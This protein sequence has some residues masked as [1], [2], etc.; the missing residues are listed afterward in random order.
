VGNLV[1]GNDEQTQ[2]VLDHD[3]LPRLLRLLDG[4]YTPYIRKEACWTVSNIAAGNK[5]QIQAVLDANFVPLL[6]HLL[7]SAEFD[8]SIKNEAGWV[9]TNAINGGTHTQIR[10]LV[11]EGVIK[12]ICDLLT[13]DDVRVV[14][15]ALK[16]LE[17]IF[18]VGA[19]DRDETGSSVNQY[20]AFVDEAGG[21]EKIKELQYHTSQDISELAG[22]LLETFTLFGSS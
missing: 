2:A 14:A 16:G 22:K 12:P 18:K 19:C 17:K 11:C 6:I 21:L 20:A 8:L 5:D 10:Y 1:V 4:P 3:V 15:E 7:A 9:L 13:W